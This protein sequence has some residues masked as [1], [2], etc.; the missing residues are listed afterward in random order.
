MNT[1][2]RFK[3]LMVDRASCIVHRSSFIVRPI[4]AV[5]EVTPIQLD[6]GGKT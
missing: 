2:A 3:E 4:L 6:P 5:L 1:I